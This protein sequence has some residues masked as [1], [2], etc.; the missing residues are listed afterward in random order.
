MV[1]ET[2]KDQM[3]TMC[4][5]CGSELSKVSNGNKNH[6]NEII[7]KLNDGAI[8]LHC[9]FCDKMKERDSTRRDVMS[10]YETPTISPT[11]SLSSCDSSVSSCSKFSVGFVKFAS[12]IFTCSR[13]SLV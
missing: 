6:Q 1:A 3:C 7:S 12:Y 13:N 9:K 4:H 2:Y 5:V 8:L 11:T 10:P